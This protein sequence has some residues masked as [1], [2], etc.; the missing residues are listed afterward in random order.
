MREFMINLDLIWF[1]LDCF[2]PTKL[3]SVKLKEDDSTYPKRN[4][5]RLGTC[6]E[7]GLCVWLSNVFVKP[8]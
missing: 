7:A 4:M 1:S 8:V 2:W 6:W 5:S 3:A